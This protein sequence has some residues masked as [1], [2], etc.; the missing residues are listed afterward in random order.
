MQVVYEKKSRFP[1]NI[2]LTGGVF[3]CCQQ[4][5]TVVYVDN[6][7]HRLHLHQS[8][9][10]LKRKEQNLFVHIGKSEAEV[11][12]NNKTNNGLEVLYC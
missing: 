8:M 5:S 7:K 1:T 6:S 4:I 11:T 12:N 9:V 10:M 2:L 3:E